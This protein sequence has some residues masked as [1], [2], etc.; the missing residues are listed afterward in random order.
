MSQKKESLSS[1]SENV[2]TYSTAIL[3]F[4]IKRIRLDLGRLFTGVFIV[5]RFP[6]LSV[7]RAI[8]PCFPLQGRITCLRLPLSV[9]LQWT[10]LSNG[11]N[12]V[13]CPMIQRFKP[14][15]YNTATQIA[16]S[17]VLNLTVYSCCNWNCADKQSGRNRVLHCF[18]GI[19]PPAY[20]QILW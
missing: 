2:Q 3:I 12:I 18:S 9:L 10:W 7:R 19:M 5:L 8:S 6:F 20:L 1:H 13:Y 17:L 4:H 14:R 16:S 11:S 15:S